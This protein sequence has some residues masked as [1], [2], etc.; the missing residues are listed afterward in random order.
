MVKTNKNLSLCAILLLLLSVSLSIRLW[1]ISFGLPGIDH[2]DESEV[3][4]HAVRFGSG[5]FNPH[6]FQYGSLFQYILFIFYGCY[7]LGGYALGGFSSVHQFAIYFVKDPTDF[8]LIARTVS[9]VLG[10]A[11]VLITYFIGENVK[12]GEVG[13]G[14]ALL[15]AVSYEHVVRSH[16]GTV[17]VALTFLF[18]LTVY[19]CLR[20]FDTDAYLGYLRA[21]LLIGFATGTKFNGIFASTAFL[22]AHFLRGNKF[23]FIEKVFNKKFGLGI[24]GI[25]VGHFIVCPFFYIDFH[26]ALFEIGQLSALHTSSHFNLGTYLREFIKNYWGI[27]AGAFCILGLLRSAIALNKREWVLIVPA[28]TVVCFASLHNYVEAKYILCVFPVF[29]V[30][31]SNLVVECLTYLKQKYLAILFI[32]LLIA[33]PLYMIIQWDYEHGQK[34]ITLEAKEWIENNIAKNAKILLDNVGNAGPKLN[35][36]KKNLEHQYKRALQH[37]LL[38]AEQLKLKLEAPSAI[39]YEVFLVDSAA[40]STQDDYVKYRLWQDTEIIGNSPEYYRARGFGYI[41]V[42]DRYFPQM[43]KGFKLIKEFKRGERGIRIYTTKTEP[44]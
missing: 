41:I 35:N 14:A 24:I 13:I 11:T 18:S 28:A 42:S 25:F 33:H 34:S 19:L 10:T 12:S 16:Y 20:I 22:A 27:P 1:G 4:N 39:Y 7:F 5:D 31:G 2:G 38:I 43:E 29:A 37:N 26:D 8:Y 3:V 9:A 30:L 17:D 21:G 23:H 44:K 15:L 40:G 32:V 6:R 36:S